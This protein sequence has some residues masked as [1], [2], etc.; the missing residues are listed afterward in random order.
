M[1]S[2]SKLIALFVGVC[3]VVSLF[4]C[5][6]ERFFGEPDEAVETAAILA[7]GTNILLVDGKKFSVFNS[8]AR[9]AP[10]EHVV[11]AA[12]E[13][14]NFQTPGR[15]SGVKKVRFTAEAGKEYVVRGSAS[16]ARGICLSIEDGASRKTVTQGCG[17][18][19]RQGR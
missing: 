4:G 14:S 16:E 15:S 10:G 13:A 9:V 12:F 17:E 11:V 7:Y 5:A 1:K 2:M 8:S 19:V 18:E 3:A 6:G